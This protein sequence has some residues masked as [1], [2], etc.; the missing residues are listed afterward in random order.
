LDWRK[1]KEHALSRKPANDTEPENEVAND[2]FHAFAR[3]MT[4]RRVA[5]ISV[6][7]SNYGDKLAPSPDTPSERKDTV[8]ESLREVAATDTPYW[9]LNASV[10]S[11]F[12]RI[13]S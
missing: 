5:T 12:L 2:D 11:G 8:I 6:T 7:H 10:E 4:L 9:A 3:H 1:G 13:V